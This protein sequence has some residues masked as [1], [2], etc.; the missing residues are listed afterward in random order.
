M[1]GGVASNT[2]PSRKTVRPSNVVANNAPD[3]L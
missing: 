2:Q 3:E 1:P